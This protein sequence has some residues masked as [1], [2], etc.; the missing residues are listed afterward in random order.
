MYYY[1]ILLLNTSKYL[2]TILLCCCCV[3][4]ARA[5]RPL[6]ADVILLFNN[7]NKMVYHAGHRHRK[8]VQVVTSVSVFCMY[9]V[10]LRIED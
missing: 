9:T 2:V 8:L 7:S 4:F 6:R 5:A 3:G 1:I 10:G